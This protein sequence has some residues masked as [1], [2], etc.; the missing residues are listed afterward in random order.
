MPIRPQFKWLYP[1]D[2]PQLSAVIRFQRA[3]AGAK[4]AVD[5]MAARSSISATVDGGTMTSRPG[6]M[7]AGDLC[8]ALLQYASMWSFEKPRSCWR[9]LTLITIQPIIGLKI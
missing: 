2:W 8:V 3:K 6:E 7:G 5:R 1:I 9:P 4:S